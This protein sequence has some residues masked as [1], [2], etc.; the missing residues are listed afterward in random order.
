MGTQTVEKIHESGDAAQSR[1]TESTLAFALPPDLL[2]FGQNLPPARVSQK[3]VIKEAWEMQF[4][5]VTPGP[6]TSIQGRA[7]KRRN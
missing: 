2:V 5:W 1:Q 4:V 7:G 6:P 3:P